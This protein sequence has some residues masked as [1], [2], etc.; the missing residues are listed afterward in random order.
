MAPAGGRTSPANRGTRPRRPQR[1]DAD[2]LLEV[3]VRVFTERGYDGTSMEDLARAARIT[4]SSFYYHVS[5]KEELLRRSLDRALDRLFAVLGEPE[6]L[7]GRAID[8]LEHV[9]RGSIEVLVDELPHVTLLLRVRGNTKVERRALE[10]RREFGRAVTKLVTE[11]VQEG[12]LRPQIDEGL[13]ARLLFGM[14]NSVVDWYRPDGGTLSAESLADAVV[15]LTID[16]WRHPG[17][18]ARRKTR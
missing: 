1:Y 15:G 12:D 9:V 3:A 2:S 14:V 16:G 18:Q 11:A 17:P 10:R 5:G 4:K 6:A 8:R 13:T 7:E